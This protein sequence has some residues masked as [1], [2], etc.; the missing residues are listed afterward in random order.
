MKAE[1]PRA[2]ACGREV[3]KEDCAAATVASAGQLRPRLRGRSQPRL[4]LLH[5]LLTPVRLPSKPRGSPQA[6]RLLQLLLRERRCQQLAA[7]RSSLQWA[8]AAAMVCAASSTSASWCAP[9]PPFSAV[10]LPAPNC[11]RTVNR[12]HGRF[13]LRAGAPRPRRLHRLPGRQ[14]AAR[15]DRHRAARRALHAPGARTRERGGLGWSH[16]AAVRPPPHSPLR[17]SAC[18]TGC[19]KGCRGAGAGPAPRRLCR[20]VPRLALLAGQH[21]GQPRLLVLTVRQRRT[22]T[23]PPPSLPSARTWLRPR[24]RRRAARRLTQQPSSPTAAAGGTTLSPLC[25]PSLCPSCRSGSRK[26]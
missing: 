18:C 26:S 12:W 2:A 23:S 6:L 15:A 13:P 24:Q 4:L 8:A 10:P 3:T 21:Q 19:W 16:A 7:W 25:W 5:P 17:R 9:P 11:L 14:R 22:P 20:P 1:T